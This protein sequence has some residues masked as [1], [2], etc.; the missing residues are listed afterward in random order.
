[1]TEWMNDDTYMRKLITKRNSVIGKWLENASHRK[2]RVIFLT[3]LAIV[4]IRTQ[5]HLCPDVGNRPRTG[6]LSF[7]V[8]NKLSPC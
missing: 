3:L 6:Q 5:Y 4:L 8:G 2:F 1:M 7:S